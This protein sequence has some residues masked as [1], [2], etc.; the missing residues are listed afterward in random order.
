MATTFKITSAI[1]FVLLALCPLG[2]SCS[3]NA[4][5]VQ[6]FGKVYTPSRERSKVDWYLLQGGS[7][8]SLLFSHY[9]VEIELRT[10][11]GRS[12]PVPKVAAYFHSE[13]GSVL[14]I[15]VLTENANMRAGEP[16]IVYLDTDGYTEF[17][18]L[19]KNEL[20]SPLYLTVYVADRGFKAKVP[21]F[22]E[23]RGKDVSEL[24]FIATTT[25][26]DIGRAKIA[27]VDDWPK[28]WQSALGGPSFAADYLRPPA[29]LRRQD[30]QRAHYFYYLKPVPFLDLKDSRDLR[31]ADD[32]IAKDMVASGITPGMEL[33]L[34]TVTP[35]R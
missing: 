5:N 22:A 13:N 6:V 25:I 10:T 21:T 15:R 28:A 29:V 9:Y 26:P 23:L 1:V 11:S 16:F 32:D 18:H 14:N 4:Q 3:K 34:I 20:S 2:C 33:V 24:S 35:M 7:Q 19:S 30:N 8:Q 12:S 17:L 31:L 27:S